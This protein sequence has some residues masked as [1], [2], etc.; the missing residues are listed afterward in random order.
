MMEAEPKKPIKKRK[1]RRPP[2]FGAKAAPREK[3][4]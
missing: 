2:A 1:T 3:A 4:V